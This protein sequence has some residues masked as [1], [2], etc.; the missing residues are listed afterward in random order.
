MTANPS[1]SA[2]H[3]WLHAGPMGPTAATAIVLHGDS[4]DF[5]ENVLRE[6]AEYL[7]EYDDEGA[8]HWLSAT[9]GLVAQISQN[10]D[11]RQLL[12]MEEGCQ[13]CPP[14]SACGVRKT[15]TALGR[16]GHVIF[17]ALFPVDKD[18]EL[19][20]AFHAGVG[21][22]VPSAAKCHLVLN[23]ELMEPSCIAHIIA[24]VF[25]E[26]LHRKQLRAARHH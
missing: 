7:N 6:I 8:G 13:D 1:L 24:D 22:S 23:P 26:C 2:F 16:R 11:L 17:Q 10:P 14:T 12:G 20:D 3:Q 19:P 5:T 25:L 21:S 4:T 15:L 18:L 9:P